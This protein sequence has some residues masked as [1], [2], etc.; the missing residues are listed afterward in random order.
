MQWPIGC[1]KSQVQHPASLAEK[2]D[3]F[4]INIFNELG[5]NGRKLNK[6]IIY[7]LADGLWSVWNSW[8][9]CSQTC[10]GGIEE[11]FRFCDSPRPLFGGK[12]CLMDSNEEYS[13]TRDCAWMDCPGLQWAFNT[14]V[15]LGGSIYTFLVNFCFQLQCDI[16]FSY[17]QFNR[18]CHF[19][20]KFFCL[21]LSWIKCHF[22]G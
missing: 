14:P 17:P 7:I 15:G 20:S 10:G 3:I 1:P 5:F 6:T 18:K 19:L 12:D 9:S 13:Q 8:T 21:S 16:W 4:D 22:C 2:W 11:R